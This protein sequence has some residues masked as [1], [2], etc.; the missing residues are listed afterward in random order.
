M[1]DILDW[2]SYIIFQKY[3]ISYFLYSPELDQYLIGLRGLCTVLRHSTPFIAFEDKTTN[4]ASLSIN[5]E[6]V[7]QPQNSSNCCFVTSHEMSVITT[8]WTC[9]RA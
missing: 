2:G 3:Q 9:V 5:S 4:I 8:E 1:D 7:I 6:N